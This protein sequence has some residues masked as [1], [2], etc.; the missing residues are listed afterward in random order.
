MIIKGKK[1]A[2]KVEL[3]SVPF[4]KKY[5][6]YAKSVIQPTLTKEASDYICEKYTEL[7]NREDGENNMHKVGECDPFR[8]YIYCN[9]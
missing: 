9:R 1:E 7:R 6:E 2:S 8:L 5:M 3:I 4:L